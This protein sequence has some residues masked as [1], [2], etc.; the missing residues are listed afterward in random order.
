ME[1]EE[2]RASI[3]RVDVGAEF[4]QETPYWPRTPW[5]QVLA[6]VISGSSQNF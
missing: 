4:I 5:L 1:V 2:N 6:T 3:L